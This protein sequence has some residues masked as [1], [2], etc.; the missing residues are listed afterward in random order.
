MAKLQLR[1]AEGALPAMA[2]AGPP[3]TGGVA[4]SVFGPG[5]CRSGGA[6]AAALTL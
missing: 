3:G 4:G 6:Q 2:Q 5:S 1:V